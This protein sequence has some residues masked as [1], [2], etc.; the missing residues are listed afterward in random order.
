MHL[1]LNNDN[2][3]RIYLTI[4]LIVFSFGA[5]AQSSSYGADEIFEKY[6]VLSVSTLEIFQQVKS[7]KRS[8]NYISIGRWEMDLEVSDIL[9]ANYKSIDQEGNEL[10]TVDSR[11]VPMNGATR[12]GGI[13]SLTVGDGFVYGYINEGDDLYYIEPARYYRKRSTSDDVIIYNVKDIKESAPGTCGFD[14]LGSKAESFKSEHSKSRM[15][16]CRAYEYAIC[17]DWSMVSKYGSAAGAENHAIG[18]TNDVNTDYIA[19]FSDEIRLVISGQYNSTCNTCDPWTSSTDISVLLAD[20]RDWSNV[21]IDNSSS[22][23]YIPHDVASLWSNRNF[24]G[25]T[26][27]LAYVGVICNQTYK[28]NVLQ[29]ISNSGGYQ[30]RVLT[31][32]EL[33]HNFGSSHDAASS[34]YI[35]AP[36]INNT[37]SWSS[38]SV[39]SINTHIAGISCHDACSG[40]DR[41]VSFATAT[42]SGSEF[43]AGST[44]GTCQEGYQDILIPISIDF[45]PGSNVVANVSIAGS[46]T[47]SNN[48][49]YQL[50]TSSVTFT[51]TGSTIQN[52]VLRVIDDRVEEID[53]TVILNLSISSGDAI[54][55]SIGQQIY[56]ISGTGDKTILECCTSSDTIFYGGPNQ[57][58]IYGI[59]DGDVTDV[60]SRMLLNAGLLQSQGLT[61]GYIDQLSI[62][63]DTK[64]STGIYNDFRIGVTEVSESNLNST[65]WYATTQVFIDD[66][67][68]TGNQWNSFD[69]QTPFLWDGTSNIYVELCFNNSTSIGGYDLI[70]GFDYGTTT[71]DQ[72]DFNKFNGGSGCSIAVSGG[73]SF[74]DQTSGNDITP[75]A[76][77]R[78]LASATTIETQ[79][80][81][82]SVGRIRSGEIA[83]LF[84][85]D[86]E[87]IASI[88]NVGNTDMECIEASVLSAGSLKSNLPFG[89]FQYS[90][91]T[92]RID[93]D[94]TAVYELSLYYTSAELATWGTGALDL[95][96]IKSS[97]NIASSSEVNS[98]FIFS[99]TVE[100]NQ[101]LSN[102]V[103]Y[104]TYVNGPGFF[105]LTDGFQCEVAGS[106]FDSDLFIE[107]LGQGILLKNISGEQ[108]VVNVNSSGSIVTSMNNA[109]VGDAKLMHGDFYLND[110]SRG[111][112]FK[113][114][115][116]TFTRVN[117]DASG[118]LIATNTST[119]SNKS[120]IVDSGN[121]ALLESGAGVVFNSSNGN[122][123]KLYIDEAGNP[124]TGIVPCG[125]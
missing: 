79:A 72:F 89:S 49:D 82:S 32:H 76:Q 103:I 111:I 23:N 120:I 40:V 78:K 63:V 48:Y 15:A 13:V 28:Y 50:V 8:S 105:A 36:S 43:S 33:G 47:A 38:T 116:S 121:M 66:I 69:F 84:S 108:Y 80:N 22:G 26:I 37:S 55:G 41:N 125:I 119:P 93:A 114:S 18:V 6:E 39:N 101:A 74:N 61:A 113:R 31:T 102:H 75:L 86:D 109:T 100:D 57:Y 53:E 59:F 60:R 19:A 104:K 122:C 14:E 51:P 65:T 87:L 17:N 52:A 62:F 10:S 42:G 67:S 30:L 7:N 4:I 107:Q 95:N 88:R 11:A 44:T 94:Y 56:T 20:F 90:D 110:S 112:M 34:G 123:Y 85:A 115:A 106:F 16:G 70:R 97:S 1:T 58:Y 21:N 118:N 91:K 92:I 45:L 5:Y 68:T 9:S 35:M 71:A 27:G 83:H 25:S 96:L 3:M 46:S 54:V 73:S 117:V 2:I 124:M 81:S 24:D 77:L 64:N 29:D 12:K 99:G 98:S